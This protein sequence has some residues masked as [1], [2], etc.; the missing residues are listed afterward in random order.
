V[1]I[2]Q[3]LNYSLPLLF[4]KFRFKESKKCLKLKI[5]IKIHHQLLSKAVRNVRI[6]SNIQGVSKPMSKILKVY[7]KGQNKKKSSYERK[8]K[9]AFPPSYSSLKLMEKI[10][11]C[12]LA[13][14]DFFTERINV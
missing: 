4:P 2:K 12:I 5:S 6:K 3:F 7:S 10:A 1:Y 11:K 9:N 14:R 13:L 8:F